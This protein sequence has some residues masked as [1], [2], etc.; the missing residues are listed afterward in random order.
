MK[1]SEILKNNKV[2]VSF[3]VFPPK[4]WD[5]LENTKN[6]VK[7]MCKYNPSFMSVT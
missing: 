5:K 2:T 1:I 3:E 6:T 7:E 4:Q